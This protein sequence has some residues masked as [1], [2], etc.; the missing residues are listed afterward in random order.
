[1]EPCSVIQQLIRAGYEGEHL[2][3]SVAV[4]ACYL[5]T[6]GVEGKR[7]R[8][9]R[10]TWPTEHVWGQLGLHVTLTQNKKWKGHF[11][12][13]EDL[14]HV[15]RVFYSSHLP[16]PLLSACLQHCSEST[17]EFFLTLIDFYNHC[18]K[19]IFRGLYRSS[20]VEELYLKSFPLGMWLGPTMCFRMKTPKKFTIRTQDGQPGSVRALV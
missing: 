12:K 2:W 1:M 7:T 10:P 14:S 17:H 8:S 13:K 6:Q 16:L 18:R 5:I 15:L 11:G 9:L 19:Q 4:N 3:L 20:P